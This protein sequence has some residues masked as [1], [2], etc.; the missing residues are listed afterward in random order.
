L[1]LLPLAAF[2]SGPAASSLAPDLPR[3]VLLSVLPTVLPLLALGAVG[4]LAYRKARSVRQALVLTTVAFLVGIVGATAYLIA[5][6]P[7][8]S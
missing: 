3:L 4:V 6:W 7:T 1:T 8:G 2:L 5:V